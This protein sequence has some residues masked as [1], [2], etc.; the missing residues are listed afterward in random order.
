MYTH[1]FQLYLSKMNLHLYFIMECELIFSYLFSFYWS[2]VNLQCCAKFLLYSK[3]IQLYIRYILSYSF[4]LWFIIGY[5]MQFSVLYTCCCCCSVTKSCL[6][7][8]DPMDCSTPDSSVF[9]YLPETAQ[10]HV[11]W[12]G[13]LILCCPLLLLSSIFP[14]IRVFSNESTLRIRWSKYWSFSFSIS[15]SNVYS[16]LSSFRLLYKNNTVCRARNVTQVWISYL[17]Y[18]AYWS[19]LI[20]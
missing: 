16:E 9:H 15:P 17:K 5:W 2:V 4:P 18:S 3:V 11:H 13:H 8:C 10:I 7:L 12:I 6:T 1:N 14:S 19:S 20:S